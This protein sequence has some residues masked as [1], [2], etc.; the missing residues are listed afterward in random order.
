LY[1]GDALGGVDEEGPD[2]SDDERDE[3]VNLLGALGERPRACQ[4]AVL[5]MRG[6][7][8]TCVLI[9]NAIRI[10][11]LSVYIIIDFKDI[12]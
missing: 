10:I 12:K 11:C 4:S 3:Q 5:S 9:R 6:I 7:L 1:L 2:H 8:W